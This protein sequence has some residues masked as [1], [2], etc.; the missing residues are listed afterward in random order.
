[1]DV[2]VWLRKY[3]DRNFEAESWGLVDG[4]MGVEG[5]FGCPDESVGLN[6]GVM[7]FRRE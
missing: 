7:Y 6:M 1:M 2:E 3:G 4:D 5:C